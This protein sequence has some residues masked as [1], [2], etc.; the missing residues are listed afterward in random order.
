MSTLKMRIENIEKKTG[1][2]FTVL[3]VP[4]DCEHHRYVE[5]YCAEHRLARD[6]QNFV[7]LN[8]SDAGL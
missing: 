3:L 4:D 5:K 7:C 6:E 1:S 2:E 8:E